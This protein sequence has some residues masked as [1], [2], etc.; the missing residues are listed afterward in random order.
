MKAVIA[1]AALCL[2]MAGCTKP[3]AL[4]GGKPAE[5]WI[6]AT[7]APDAATRK[8]AVC[9]LG[10]AGAPDAEAWAALSGALRDKHAGVRC[11]AILALMKCGRRA[12]EVVPILRELQQRDPDR[13]VRVYA[14]KA[15]EKIVRDANGGAS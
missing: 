12:E 10:N 7:Q 4:S 3:P 6:K 9:K 5:Y 8:T 14:G 11:E 15:A 2:G 13:Q 1:I